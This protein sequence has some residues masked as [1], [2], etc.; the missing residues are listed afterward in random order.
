[1]QRALHAIHQT[2]AERILRK[3]GR[4]DEEIESSEA[5]GQERKKK[6]K[7]NSINS[8]VNSRIAQR[9]R[10]LNMSVC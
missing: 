3:R 9:T 7:T 1:M 5:T 6:Q 2:G 4:V 10:I 8:M